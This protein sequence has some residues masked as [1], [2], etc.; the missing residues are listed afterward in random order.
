MKR[1]SNCQLLMRYSAVTLFAVMSFIRIDAQSLI[2]K[3][4]CNRRYEKTVDSY[5]YHFNDTYKFSKNNTG[6]C[7][8]EGYE[9]GRLFAI[10]Y[11]KFT[12]KLENNILT[13]YTT[14]YNRYR[15]DLGTNEK[16]TENIYK[17]SSVEIRFEGKDVVYFR[18]G[19]NDFR[20]IRD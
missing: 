17:Y 6:K 12:W 1:L 10:N 13:F 3:W 5:T 15:V 9:N 19:E 8:S 18:V 20:Y 16:V 14:D 7:K 2:G 4:V 11:E